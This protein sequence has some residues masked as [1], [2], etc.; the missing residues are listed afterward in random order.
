MI[1]FTRATAAVAATMALTALAACHS[2]GTSTNSVSTSGGAGQPTAAGVTHPATSQEWR[3]GGRFVGPWPPTQSPPARWGKAIAVKP[4]VSL[5]GYRYTAV[6][7]FGPALHY[8]LHQQGFDC[9]ASSDYTFDLQPGQYAVPFEETITNVLSQEAPADTGGFGTGPDVLQVTGQGSGVT[10]GDGSCAA[11]AVPQLPPHGSI[12]VY[13]YIGP[14][15]AKYLNQTVITVPNGD[16]SRTVGKLGA[17][18][19]GRALPTS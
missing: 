3:N 12:T 8:G 2:S 6:L 4:P 16:G 19:P 1:R 15:A 5:N 11:G 9:Q 14:V 18:T 17:L 13:G 10:F 7:R